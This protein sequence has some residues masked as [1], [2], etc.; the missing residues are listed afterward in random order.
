MSPAELRKLNVE[1]FGRLLVR[2][3]DPAERT[4]IARFIAEEHAK[5]DSAYPDDRPLSPAVEA[6]SRG[7]PDVRASTSP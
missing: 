3:T 1:H 6:R 5:P 2:T 4:R 7:A